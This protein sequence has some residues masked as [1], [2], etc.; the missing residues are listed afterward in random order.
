MATASFRSGAAG[1]GGVKTDT[2]TNRTSSINSSA[3]KSSFKSKSSAPPQ[4]SGPRRNSTGSVATST[5]ER[6]GGILYLAPECSL[7][8]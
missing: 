2:I 7:I 4:N 6:G 5:K 1:R 3:P 8:F